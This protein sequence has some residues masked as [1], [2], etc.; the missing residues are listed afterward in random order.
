V[1]A[2]KKRDMRAELL[3]ESPLKLLVKLSVPGS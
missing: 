1:E 3:S 2:A